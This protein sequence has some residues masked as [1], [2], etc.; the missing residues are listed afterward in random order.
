MKDKPVNGKSFQKPKE[1]K[2]LGNCKQGKNAGICSE[3]RSMISPDYARILFAISYLARSRRI[4][5]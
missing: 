2:I 1:T 3:E 4:R 5:N